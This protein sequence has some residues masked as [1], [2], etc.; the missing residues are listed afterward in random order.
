MGGRKGHQRHPRLP[1]GLRVCVGGKKR[2][3]AVFYVT[4]LRLPRSPSSSLALGTSKSLASPDRYGVRTRESTLQPPS[5]CGTAFAR[6][7]FCSRCSP[8]L[9]PPPLLPFKVHEFAR[10]RGNSRGLENVGLA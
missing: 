1:G 2:L 6:L 4:F 10:F 3:S 9:P 5:P 7:V 8:P